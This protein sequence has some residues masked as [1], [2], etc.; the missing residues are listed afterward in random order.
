MPTWINSS[1]LFRRKD[2]II[3]NEALSEKE[4]EEAIRPK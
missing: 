1:F 2:K 3:V 4:E